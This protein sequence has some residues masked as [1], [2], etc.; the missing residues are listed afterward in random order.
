MSTIKAH[1][2]FRD[3]LGRVLCV[4]FKSDFELDLGRCFTD[5]SISRLHGPQ[6]G[7]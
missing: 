1:F 4:V 2:W 6:P 3:H 5:I 7:H